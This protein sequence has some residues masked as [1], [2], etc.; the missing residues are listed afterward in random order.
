MTQAADATPG[1]RGGDREPALSVVLP[2]RRF[3]DVR[4][5][6]RHLRAQSGRERIELVLVAPSLQELGLREQ[7]VAGFAGVRVVEAGALREIHRAYAAGVR[8]ARAPVVAFAEDHAFP[9]PGWAEALLGRHAEPWAVV[10]PEVANANPGS[11]TS[12]ADFLIGYGHWMPPAPRGPAPFLPGHNSSYKRDVL[13]E[14]GTALEEKLAS[15]TV[16]HFELAEAGRG[17]YVEPAAR[18]A[19]VNFSRLASALR[20]QW[21]AGRA[22]AAARSRRWSPARRLLYVA[23]FP[24]FP[25]LRVWRT[26]R[27]LFRPGRPRGMA[28]SVTPLL[29]LALTVEAVGQVLGYA[30]G[31]GDVERRLAS[32]DFDRTQH[33]NA[34]DRRALVEPEERPFR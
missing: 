8:S 1:S 21:L 19:H 29:A 13:L 4:R 16:F 24:L 28:V 30:V 27:L 12:R 15:E 34:S 2:A 20:L 5:T 18:I 32:L 3:A 11:V 22:F 9:E 14:Q 6:L 31:A 26:L 23:A 33:L 7:E 25:P 17:L 10:G